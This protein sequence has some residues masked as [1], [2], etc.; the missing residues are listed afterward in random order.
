MFDNLTYCQTV[1]VKKKDTF[2][3]FQS[4]L[5]A[6]FKASSGSAGSKFQF[7]YDNLKLTVKSLFKLTTANSN[8]ATQTL[9]LL[10]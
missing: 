5:V 2:E 10:F 4:P 3:L 8:E 7:T 9:K 6:E 1:L